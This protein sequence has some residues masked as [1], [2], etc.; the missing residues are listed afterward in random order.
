MSKRKR[1]RMKAKERRH[2]RD[3]QDKDNNKDAAS[4]EVPAASG[5]KGSQP[6][7]STPAST[8]AIETTPSVKRRGRPPKA[9]SIAEAEGLQP[10]GSAPSVKR[11]GRPAKTV[12]GPASEEEGDRRPRP[13]S[14]AKNKATLPLELDFG[15]SPHLQYM[16]PGWQRFYAAV[17]KASGRE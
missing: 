7:T 5:A 4:P 3:I 8:S 2:Q 9:A 10:S 16:T 11:K 17:R 14:A 6:E 13:R 12:R 15:A 1:E